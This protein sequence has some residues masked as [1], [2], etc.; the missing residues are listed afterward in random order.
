MQAKFLNQ[1]EIEQNKISHF[2]NVNFTRNIES[3]EPI[4]WKKKPLATIVNNLIFED[5]NKCFFFFGRDF[6]SMVSAFDDSFLSSD[7]DTNQ[8]LV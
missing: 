5:S 6:Q 7:Q 4:L 8:F 3:L 1:T 2:L